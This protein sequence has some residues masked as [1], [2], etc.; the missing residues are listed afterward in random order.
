MTP[1]GSFLC[2]G[3]A[4]AFGAMAIFGKLAFD[5]GANAGTLL[6]VRFLV[7]AAVLWC[8]LLASG[9]LPALRRLRRRD[10]ATAFALGA[11]GYA[12]QSGCYILALE[13][14]D[15]SLLS[16][17]LY[18]FP[19]IVTVAAV[20]LGRERLDRRRVVALGLVSAGLTLVLAGAGTGALEGVGVALALGAAF[21]YSTYILVSDGVAQRLPALMLATLVCTGA[22]ISLTVGSTVAG[23]FHPGAVT[24]AGWGWLA[25]LAVVSTVAAIVMFFAGLSRVG[26]TAA[27]ILSTVEPVV[28]VAL[29]SAVFAERLTGAQLAGGA[30]VL[31]AV[32]VLRT[33]RVPQRAAERAVVAPRERAA[34]AA[35]AVGLP[36]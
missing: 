1:G 7:A 11:C 2:L 23:Q 19:A 6:A 20:A 14:I 5:E 26:P 10:V 8:V 33:G 3:S 36:R 12:L 21:V 22:A 9:A 30:L 13:R 17:L 35:P 4:T 27:S 25:G 15:A 24:A 31:T 16:L 29:A 18:T 28:T 32:V 34:E